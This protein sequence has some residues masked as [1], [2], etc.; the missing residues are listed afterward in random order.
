[1][2]SVILCYYHLHLGSESSYSVNTGVLVV[3]KVVGVFV[4]ACLFGVLFGTAWAAEPIKIGYLATLTGEGATWGAMNGT[5]RSSR[6]K[7]STRRAAFSVVPLELVR[8]PRTRGGRHQRGPEAHRGRQGRRDRR[9]ELQRAEY[10]GRPD[11]GRGMVRRSA[12]SRRIRPS[13]STPRRKSRGR[14]PSVSATPTPTRERSWPSTSS[15]S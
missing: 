15:T 13:R 10:R 7:R 2:A 9:H 5:E 11:R 6:L 3:R 14:I 8:C 4:V 1:M 12:P